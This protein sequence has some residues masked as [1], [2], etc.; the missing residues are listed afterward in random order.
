MV[1]TQANILI[2]LPPPK[3]VGELFGELLFAKPS[4]IAFAT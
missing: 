1:G 3:M 4:G 2:K